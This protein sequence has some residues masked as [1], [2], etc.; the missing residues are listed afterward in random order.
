METKGCFPV[1]VLEPDGGVVLRFIES[2]GIGGKIIAGCPQDGQVLPL[3][4][5]DGAGEAG[6]Q[7]GELDAGDEL[8]EFADG[9]AFRAG[10]DVA[11]GVELDG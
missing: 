11:R 5:L 4:P 1:V 7:G 3:E 10:A 2:P 9:E 8:A 6:F